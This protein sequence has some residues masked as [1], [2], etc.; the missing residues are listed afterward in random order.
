MT[1]SMLKTDENL[2]KGKK[3]RKRLS[4]IDSMNNDWFNVKKQMKMFT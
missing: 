4:E 1:S 2:K 3:E